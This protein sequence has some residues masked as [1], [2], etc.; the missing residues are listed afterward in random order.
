MLEVR[1][2]YFKSERAVWE[3]SGSFRRRC[4]KIEQESEARAKLVARA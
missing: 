4:N 3:I 2:V 1:H